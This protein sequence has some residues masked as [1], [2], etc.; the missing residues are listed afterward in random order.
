[1]KCGADIR[2]NTEATPENVMAERPDAIV[3]ACGAAPARPPIPG[4]N[5][6]N[7]FNVLDVDSGRR[8][9]SGTVVVC[10]GGISGCE[11]ALTLAMEGCAVTVVDILPVTA[12]AS[13]MAELTRKMLFFLLKE[14]S[15]NL[16]GEHLVR[17][18]E[19]NS[20]LIEDKNWKSRSIRADYVVEAFGMKN[21]KSLTES[22][23][24]L[25]PEVYVVGDAFEVRNIKYANLTAYDYSCNI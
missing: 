6:Q 22:F 3:V 24:G 8:K 25:I 13:G 1:M 20:V 15:V 16:V 17:S 12:F 10:G 14:K 9:V 19:E 5:R 4:L 18:I 11:S 21:D 23:T 2:L 7:V